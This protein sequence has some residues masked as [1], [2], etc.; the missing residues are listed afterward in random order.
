[1]DTRRHVYDLEQVRNA[2]HA[3]VQLMQGVMDETRLGRALRFFEAGGR[4][5]DFIRWSE[6]G[7]S[8]RA[9]CFL[10]FW[11]A[12]ATIIGDPSNDHDYQR[13]PAE[14]RL[15]KGYYT[16]VPAKPLTEKRN[17]SAAH[18]GSLYDEPEH[19]QRGHKECRGAAVEA[20]QAYVRFL[21]SGG[22]LSVDEN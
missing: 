21:Q 14:L 8:A 20:I 15:G 10:E 12:L 9:A 5:Y 6:G 1:M 2:F 13:R 4:L 19:L 18:A 17:S 7:P 22:R 16:R 3:A 11:K